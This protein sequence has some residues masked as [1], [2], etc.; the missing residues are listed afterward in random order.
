MTKYSLYYGVLRDSEK[1][2]TIKLGSRNDLNELKAQ[3]KADMKDS[4]ICS[5]YSF[6]VLSTDMGLVNRYKLT[7]VDEPKTKSKKAKKEE[8]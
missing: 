3:C 7:K 1:L 4:K 6:L 8:S 2:E 5:K